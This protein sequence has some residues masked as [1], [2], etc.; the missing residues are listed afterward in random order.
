M[1][2]CLLV[3]TSRMPPWPATKRRVTS[4]PATLWCKPT[5]SDAR[6]AVAA[7]VEAVV[8]VVVRTMHR[9]AKARR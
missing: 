3:A 1:W 7:A 4:L 6:S 8:V 2:E 5:Q 9:L